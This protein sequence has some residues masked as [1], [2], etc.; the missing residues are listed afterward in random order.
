MFSK[1]EDTVKKMYTLLD[2]IAYIDPSYKALAR[3]KILE[4]YP[5]FKFRVSEEKSQQP[6]GMIV[7]A[8]KL[9]EKKERVD[10][11]QNKEIPENAAEIAD[12]KAKGD[13]KE[14]QEYKSAKEKQHMLNLELS[15]LQEE[16]NHAVVCDPT[17]STTAI[18]SF[19]TVVTL[20]DNT[21]GKDE[22]Y[23]ILGPWESDP[24]N[25]VISYMSPF[26]NA[27]MDK[28]VG[29]SVQFTINEH[30]YNYTIKDIAK[31]AKI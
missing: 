5:D 7:T 22:K 31:A 11:L 30:K 1:D 25:N 20:T 21:S 14:N 9:A 18:V 8:K 13:L 29:T 17:T 19:G 26:G 27:I 6:K 10:I 23:T 24:D 16:L 4:K 3:N 2:D 15:R 12:A 28:K